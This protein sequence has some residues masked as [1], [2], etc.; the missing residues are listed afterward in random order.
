MMIMACEVLQDELVHI[1]REDGE[2]QSILL[3]PPLH[4]S[5]LQ[6]KLQNAG[7]GRRI[8]CINTQLPKREELLPGYSVIISMGHMSLHA[9]PDAL[10]EKVQR[11]MMAADEVADSI[12]LLYGL[13]GNALL[14]IDAF[15]QEVRAPVTIVRDHNGKIADDCVGMLV[16]ERQQYLDLLR[17]CHGT[18]FM[19][20]TWA[21]NWRRFMMDIQLVRDGG[22]IEG[23]GEVFRYMGYKRVVMLDSSVADQTDFEKKVREFA[24][25]FGFSLE[26]LDC[27]T[28]LLEEA[29][30]QAKEYIEKGARLQGWTPPLPTPLS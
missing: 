17:R 14:N 18:F 26:R 1:L 19:S 25:H 15:A 2:V 7:L 5:M 12:L 21:D 23:A 13:C 3:P 30:A 28:T 6:V 16:G 20:S 24:A 22:D 10:Q 4:G 8:R 29:Y 11:E 27:R 9:N